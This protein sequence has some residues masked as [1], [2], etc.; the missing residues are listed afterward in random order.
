M[1]IQTASL[2]VVIYLSAQATTS[3]PPV[4]WDN[5]PKKKLIAADAMKTDVFG[6]DTDNTGNMFPVP[7]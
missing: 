1:K 2:Q 4:N 5:F 3:R 7:N 6:I